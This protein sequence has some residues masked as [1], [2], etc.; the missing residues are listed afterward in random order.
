MLLYVCSRGSDSV[1]QRDGER[2]FREWEADGGERT[3]VEP[4]VADLRAA[5]RT[6]AA[7]GRSRGG[8]DQ[9][10]AG[11]GSKDQVINAVS[12]DAESDQLCSTV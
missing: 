10:R 2:A 4:R 8:T 7:A 11:G 9:V 6:V 5:S 1:G 3:T 12:S